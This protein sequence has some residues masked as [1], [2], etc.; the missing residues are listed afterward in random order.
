M[1]NKKRETLI[2]ILLTALVVV[3]VAAWYILSHL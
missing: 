3:G 1:R 2:V